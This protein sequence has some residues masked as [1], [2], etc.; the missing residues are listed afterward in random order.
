ME[1]LNIGPLELV[2]ILVIALVVLGPENMVKA[3]KSMGAWIYKLVRSPMWADFLNISREIREFPEKIVRE[4][5]LD[6]NLKEFR[7]TSERLKQ[8]VKI[9]G[10]TIDIG[11]FKVGIP[12]ENTIRKNKPDDSKPE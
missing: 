3:A 5:G 2:F 4:A 11:T 10:E 8:D 7:E 1:I 6:E 12:T 9:P